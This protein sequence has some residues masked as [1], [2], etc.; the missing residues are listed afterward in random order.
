V[1]HQAFHKYSPSSINSHWLLNGSPKRKNAFLHGYQK[2]LITS[3]YRRQPGNHSPMA[4]DPWLC[5][6][7]FQQLCLFEQ[8]CGI[9]SNTYAI[10]RKKVYK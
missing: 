9:E 4:L 5:V 3:N 10:E 8:Y 1:R 6:T 7:A 2:A